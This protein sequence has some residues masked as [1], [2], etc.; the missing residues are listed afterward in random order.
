ME[1]KNKKASISEDEKLRTIVSVLPEKPGSYQFYNDKGTVIYVGKAKNLRK[2]VSSY[3]NKKHTDAKTRILVRQIK[4]IRYVI[5]EN[6]EDALLLENNLIKEY[7]PR[8][9]ILLKDDKRYPS[10]VIKKE[11]FPRIYQT[12]D[13]KNDGSNYYGPYASVFVARTM[14]DLIKELYPIRT[15]RYPLTKENIEQEKYKTCLQY[16][17]KRCKGP[18]E[19]LQSEIEY[20]ENIRNI[21]EILRGNTREVSEHIKEEMMN[22]AENLNFEYAEELKNKLKL[23][24]DYRAKSVIVPPHINNVDVFS[25]EEREHSVFMNYMHIGK[26]AVTI[27]YTFEYKKKIDE[28]KEE[29][30]SSGIMEMRN[31]FKSRAKEIIVPFMPDI[32]PQQDI[33]VTI[34]QKGDKKK[35]L[36]LSQQNTRQY[37]ID[38]LKRS[39]KLN[40]EQRVVRFLKQV[41]KDLNI[42]E[43][44]MH[45]ECFDNSNTQGTNPVSA[46]VVFKKGKPSKKDYRHFKVKTV[47]GPN[48][49][50]TMDE[51]IN[52]RYTRVINENLPL[53]QLIVVDGGKGQLHIA[54]NRL[55]SLNLY[56]KISVVGLAERLEE[57]YYP[58]DPVP[59][60]LDKNS[61]TL[62]LLQH[63]RDEAHRFGINFHRKLRSKSQIA[64]E[65]DDIKGIGP[66]T[67]QALL[68]HFKSIKNIRQATFE[69]LQAV[70]GTAKSKI[71]CEYLKKK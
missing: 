40:P 14:L 33:T 55:K 61:E 20:D 54:I 44:P 68:K 6:E 38:Q 36:L 10:I 62:K 64:S 12:R 1:Q 53:P 23:I 57:V 47:V 4:D 46:C 19:G 8:Y 43:V 9:N 3:F 35:L 18:C 7:K 21:K 65:L 5:V 66:V 15:C 70:I 37:I 49:Y 29:L 30:L 67:K 25:F 11:H 52:R 60:I 26:G 16:H 31:R 17:I 59:L 42:P 58:N 45:I 71:V 28:P 41:Q 2:R 24:E 13:I 48:D 34:P 22:A 50:D 69:E 51:A 32:L 27:V 39:E 63:L 56:P